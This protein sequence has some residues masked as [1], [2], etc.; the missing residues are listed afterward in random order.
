LR[1]ESDVLEIEDAGA[2]VNLVVD[3]IFGPVG[4]AGL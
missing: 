4:F 3:E 1:V 2:F